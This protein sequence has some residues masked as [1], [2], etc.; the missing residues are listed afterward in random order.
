VYWRIELRL[1]VERVI[2]LT[3]RA[4]SAVQCSAVQCGAVG[5]PSGG[6]QCSKS[7]SRYNQQRDRLFV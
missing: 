6:V 7:H 3:G 1:A 4:A 2:K 5:L